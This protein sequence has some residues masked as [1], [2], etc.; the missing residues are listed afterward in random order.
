MSGIVAIVNTD[1]T[2][3]DAERLRDL[4]QALVFR[5]PDGNAT[6]V[7]GESGLG[8]T[9]FRTTD[10]SAAE[11]QPLSLD[12]EVW[13]VADCR[14]DDRATLIAALRGAGVQSQAAVPDVELILRAYLAWGPRCVERLIG[15]FSFAIWDARDRTLF[16]ARDHFGV[17]PLFYAQLDGLLIVSNTLSCIRRHPDV[18]SE[19]NE[20]AIGEF[21]LFGQNFYPA[22][23]AFRHIQRLPEAHTL[24]CCNGDVRVERYWQVPVYEEPVRL[25]GGEIVERFQELMRTAVSDRLRGQPAAIELSGGVDST[26]VAAAAF[27]LRRRN[28]IDVVPTAWTFDHRQ[29][30]PNDQDSDMAGLTASALGFPHVR[31]T[32]AGFSLFRDTAGRG[33]APRPEPRDLSFDAVWI[34]WF[35]SIAKSSR[36]L[37]TGQ[38]GDGVFR[39][40]PPTMR[41]VRRRGGWLAIAGGCVSYALRHHRPPPLGIRSGIRQLAGIPHY[42]VPPFP[43]W[44]D[45]EFARRQ[46]LKERWHDQMG[47]RRKGPSAALRPVATQCLR[48]AWATT[49]LEPYDADSTGALLEVRHPLLDLRLVDFLLRVPPMPWFWHKELPRRA[50]LRFVPPAIRN[51]PKVPPAANPILI[52]LDRGD[53]FPANWQSDPS[54]HSYVRCDQIPEVLKSISIAD[55]LLKFSITYPISLSLWLQTL[56]GA[57]SNEEHTRA[58]A[59]GR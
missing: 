32:F 41:D 15:D 27:D 56:T 37:L 35:R 40:Q 45:L 54:L 24:R 34:H 52:A 26:S 46:S 58:Y 10:E 53:R 19:V 17:K 8:A 13:I 11:C 28:D 48:D 4:T 6:K 55:A 33:V 23:T 50:C 29:L 3:C 22:I 47:L 1:G 59:G 39:I 43:E 14:V 21:L 30:I 38:G 9:L 49:I 31:Q 57:S 2:P 5:G 7:C 20:T 51:R 42:T 12:G 25:H 36:V 44:I 16:A 18:P